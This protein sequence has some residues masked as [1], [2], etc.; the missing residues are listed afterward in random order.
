[1]PWRVAEAEV[2]PRFAGV[3]GFVNAVADG[4][5]GAGQTFAAGNI[6][7]VWIGGCDGDGADRLRGLVVEDGRPGAAVIVGLPDAAIHGA[8]IENIGLARHAARGASASAARGADHAPAHFLVRA[9]GI[10]A[11]LGRDSNRERR[12]VRR[13][14]GE[15]CEKN[16]SRVT[17]GEKNLGRTA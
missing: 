17:S 16:G 9:L 14:R 11:A 10:S 5:I 1:M 3:G 13:V 6:N 7:D 15:E 4:E 2:R 12:K 8:D